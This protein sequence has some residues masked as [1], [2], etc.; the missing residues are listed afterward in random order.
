MAEG[1]WIWEF[2]G[3]GIFIWMFEY[4]ICLVGDLLVLVL[5]FMDYG[6]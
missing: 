3:F 2:M 6:F 4:D 5:G 1:D